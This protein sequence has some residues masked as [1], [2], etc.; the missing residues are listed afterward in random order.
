MDEV[1][2]HPVADGTPQLQH[3]RAPAGQPDPGGGSNRPPGQRGPSQPDA[4][5]VGVDGLA[6]QQATAG[7]DG[8]GHRGQRPVPLDPQGVQR[9]AAP[10]ADAK[11][12]PAPRQLVERGDGRGGGPGVAG[13]GVGYARAH[14]DGGG[15][16]G[17]GGQGHV[18]VS[19]GQTLVV[20]P[21]PLVP[22][23]LA[24]AGQ[25]HHPL[26]GLG[27]YEVER[28]P[29]HGRT[30]SFSIRPGPSARP[31]PLPALPRPRPEPCRRSGGR[32][33]GRS[34]GRR[35]RSSSRPAPRRPRRWPL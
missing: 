4:A 16:G 31:G 9:Q 12:G 3:P 27:G 22:E 6:P 1:E 10:G 11:E 30:L 7:V 18:H 33:P 19:G 29:N 8:L 34:G 14:L 23:L 20:D 13:V 32:R 15:G 24:Q 26:D 2:H 28:A 25:G 17:D 21:A 5:A 35:R